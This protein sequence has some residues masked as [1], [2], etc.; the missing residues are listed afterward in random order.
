MSMRP[1]DMNADAAF[2]PNS[3]LVTKDIGHGLR[4][5]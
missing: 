5:Y 4:L 2:S 3:A 1:P